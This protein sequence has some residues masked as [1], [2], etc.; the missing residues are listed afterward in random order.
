MLNRI[1]S[2][3]NLGKTIDLSG[4]IYGPATWNN[5]GF[6]KRPSPYYY[7]LAG[8]IVEFQISSILE[9]GTHFGGSTLS[10]NEGL[11]YSEVEKPE[12]VTVDVTDLNRESLDAISY[13]TKIVGDGSTEETGNE[14]KKIINKIDMLYIDAL[15]DGA[16]VE[17]VLGNFLSLDPAI[18]VFDDIAIHPSMR[19]FW[20]S[21]STRSDFSCVNV[22]DYFPDVRDP[23]VGFGFAIK[24]QN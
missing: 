1:K 24:N 12:I 21:F 4:C 22:S 11:K 8:L 16:F 10:M 3:Y 17:R 2:A 15:K 6:V 20:S 19:E 9:I 18:I 23:K 13:L 7:F 14:I 5:G